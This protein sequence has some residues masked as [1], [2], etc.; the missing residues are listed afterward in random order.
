MRVITARGRALLVVGGVLTLAGMGLGFRELTRA[1]LLC[2]ALPVVAWLFS[3]GSVRIAVARSMAP[4]RVNRGEPATVT[5]TA[6]NLGSR[7]TPLLLAQEEVAVPLGDRPHVLIPR[8]PRGE[9][10]RAA[11][12]VRSHVRG[13]HALG[14]LRAWITDPFGLTS[15]A[16]TFPGQA[17]LIVL[18][19]IIPLGVVPAGL[20]GG[21][22]D[23]GGSHRIALHGQDDLTVRDYREGD[24]LRRIHWPSTARTGEL[25]VRQDEQPGR[26]RTL[27][28]FDNRAHAFASEGRSETFEW[29]VTVTASF[30]VHLIAHGHEVYLATTG[31]ESTGVAGL[32]SVEGVLDLFAVITPSRVGSAGVFTHAIHDLLRRG[33][34][35][36]IAVLGRP[37]ALHEALDAPGTTPLAFVVRSDSTTAT[38][39]PTL[40][41][42]GWH[43]VATRPGDDLAAQWQGAQTRAARRTA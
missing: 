22:G 8:T 23:I 7:R 6:T 41:Q 4:H 9:E 3:R 43:V 12:L 14:P 35:H 1:G 34:G 40:S 37:D 30:V 28:L 5:I 15:R 18:P 25:M 19:R 10:R 16:L 21:G 32:T 13:H 29:A 2:A 39:S 26:R 42:R 24:D 33:G 31:G 20:A 38:A 11:Y 27:I 17:H 36:V